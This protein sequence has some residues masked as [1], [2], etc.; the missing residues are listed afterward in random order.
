M[1]ETL[2]IRGSG[3]RLEDIERVVRDRALDHRPG[4]EHPRTSCCSQPQ[5]EF[6][7]ARHAFFN[8]AI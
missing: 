1:P 5:L 4:R 2:D 8:V 3:L 7:A 6:S